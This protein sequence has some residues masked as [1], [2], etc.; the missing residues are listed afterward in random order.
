[1]SVGRRLVV[2]GDVGM[3]EKDAPRQNYA[4]FF[5]CAREGPVMNAK[6]NITGQSGAWTQFWR[7]RAHG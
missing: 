2:V 1:M 7:R 6:T 3:E 5:V 4:R